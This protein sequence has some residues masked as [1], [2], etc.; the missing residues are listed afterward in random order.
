MVIELAEKPINIQ[1][2]EHLPLSLDNIGKLGKGTK[3]INT[4]Y[5]LGEFLVFVRDNK[6]LTQNFEIETK[7]K[8]SLSISCPEPPRYDPW[9]S[10]ILITS[11]LR[12]EK[13]KKRAGDKELE[14]NFIEILGLLPTEG[15]GEKTL[16]DPKKS[17]KLEV[18]ITEKEL[19]AIIE[20]IIGEKTNGWIINGKGFIERTLE[21]VMKRYKN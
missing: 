18:E 8:D 3:S 16:L 17:I 6:G 20:Q 19:N 1:K 12:D 10:F 9:K 14:Y 5:S 2:S 7:P 15:N 11:Q 13:P 21:N 4:G